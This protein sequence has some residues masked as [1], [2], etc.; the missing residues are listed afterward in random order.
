LIFLLLEGQS[1]L[2]EADF[3]IEKCPLLSRHGGGLD[4][5]GIAFAFERLGGAFRAGNVAFHCG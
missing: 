5:Q 4:A 2:L 3:L 1:I